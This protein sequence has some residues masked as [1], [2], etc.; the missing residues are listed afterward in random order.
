MAT[1]SVDNPSTEVQLF[2]RR[3]SS[4]TEAEKE[5]SYF[6]ETWLFRGQCNALWGLQCNLDRKRG[7]TD[8][9][10]AEIAVRDAFMQRAHLFLQA[11]REPESPLE[12]LSL[13]QH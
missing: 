8:P 10:H 7:T 1:I 13:I 11:A 2:V 3:A 5:L 12:W 9:I 4:W 6:D